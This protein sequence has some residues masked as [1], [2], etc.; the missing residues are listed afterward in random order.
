MSLNNETHQPAPS[1][2]MT[3]STASLLAAVDYWT[4]EAGRREA[5]R[6]SSRK[7]ELKADGSFETD[8]PLPLAAYRLRA[9]LTNYRLDQ[10]FMIPDPGGNAVGMVDLGTIA[11][12][13]RGQN[14]NS[15]SAP[16]PSR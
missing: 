13:G 16:A 10:E 12:S 1:A 4:S 8:E 2:E 5:N 9:Y 7:L 15:Q 6:S 11:V 14:A 3:P